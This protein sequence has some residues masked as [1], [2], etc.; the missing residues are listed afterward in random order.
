MVE[1]MNFFEIPKWALEPAKPQD[2]HPSK[3][4]E[5]Y[6]KLQ[7]D[8]QRVFAAPPPEDPIPVALQAAPKRRGRPPKQKE[9]A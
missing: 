6:K 4:A 1:Q 5:L 2:D 9:Q 7:E 3:A 8:A